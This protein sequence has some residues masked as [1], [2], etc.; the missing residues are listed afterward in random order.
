MKRSAI[1]ASAALATLFAC[2]YARLTATDVQFGDGAEL[3]LAAATNGVAH[4]PGYP[5]WIML[6]HALT[7]VPAGTIPFRVG[8]FSVICHALTIG[9]VCACGITL[10]RNLLAGIFAGALLG[11]TPLF[12]TWSIQPEVFA[13]NDLFVAAIVLCVTLLVTQTGAW[14]LFVVSCALLGLGL[15]NQQEIIALAPLLLAVL[16]Y[17]RQELPAGSARLGLG[18]L[19]F[20]VLFA[21][22]ALP[23]LHT[24]IASQHVVPWPYQT[25]HSLHDLIDV[26]SRKEF[27][28]GS[29]VPSKELEG[30]SFGER[31]GT[32]IVALWPLW[33]AVLLGVFLTENLKVRFWIPAIWAVVIAVAFAFVANINVESELLASTFRRFTLEPLVMLTPYAAFAVSGCMRMLQKRPRLANITGAVLVALVLT[34]GLASAQTRSLRD[35]HDVRTFVDDVFAT[36]PHGAALLAWD[37]LYFGTVPYFQQAEHL[38]P[39]V[40]FVVVP[41]LLHDAAP[42]YTAL[43]EREGIRLDGVAD[44][45]DGVAARDALARANPSRELYV[46]GWGPFTDPTSYTVSKMGLTGP[47]AA[48]PRTDELAQLYRKNAALMSA[49]D[50]GN[51]SLDPARTNGWGIA[52]RGQYGMAFFSMGNEAKSTG[53]IQAARASYT[54]ALQYMPGYPDITSALQ[55][56]R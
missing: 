31:L 11:A 10:T 36:L 55:S 44:A 14:W 4:P 28:S 47:L 33:P 49:P 26:I 52:L 40:A 45:S 19:A 42:D 25:A 1:L 7:L 24:I 48:H 17:K 3:T 21:G 34:A 38:R 16:W 56:L 15:A 12:V 30:S 9:L 32:T 50:Y 39:D 37:D 13:L 23:Y 29:L 53:D 22:F 20:A 8:L 2:W 43:V 5:L 51:V 6:A 41:L 27:G 35:E 54:R 18:V 46:A